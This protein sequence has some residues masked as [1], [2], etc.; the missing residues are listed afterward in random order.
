MSCTLVYAIIGGRFVNLAG[1]VRVNK[2]DC[3]DADQDPPVIRLF[4]VCMAGFWN[5]K[6]DYGQVKS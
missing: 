4:E 2:A 3:R 1:P 5:A 6:M